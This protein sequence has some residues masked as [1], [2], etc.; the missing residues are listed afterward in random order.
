[1]M[2]LPNTVCRSQI[3]T[4]SHNHTT[5]TGRAVYVGSFETVKNQ[6]KIYLFWTKKYLFFNPADHNKERKLN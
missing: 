4:F 1:M 6:F 3:K 2:L 5:A